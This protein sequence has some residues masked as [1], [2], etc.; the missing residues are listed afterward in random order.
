MRDHGWLRLF[1]VVWMTRPIKHRN[2]GP[3]NEGLTDYGSLWLGSDDAGQ[4]NGT[5]HDGSSGS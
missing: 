1:V 2:R 5:G 4:H 3:T